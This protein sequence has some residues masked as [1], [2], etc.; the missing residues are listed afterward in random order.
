MKRIIFLLG[1]SFAVLNT[2]AAQNYFTKNGMLSFFSKSALENITAVNN[3]V[4][5]VLNTT[6]GETKFSAI[7][8][9]FKFKK[10]L[11]QEHFNENYMESD[12]YP[13]A[14]FSGTIT[15]P[16]KISFTKDGDYNVNVSGDL[17]M[18]GVTKKI[19]APTTITV[20]SGKLTG[21]S[22]FTVLL[23]DYNISVPKLVENN[24]AKSIEIKVNCSYEPK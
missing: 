18:H 13:K 4:V 21:T 5:S 6:T 15:D 3:Q 9:G 19:S 10:A 22:T 23:A 24:I 20:R 1:V 11:M 17:A 14:T 7:I 8:K 12:K 16:G 2:S